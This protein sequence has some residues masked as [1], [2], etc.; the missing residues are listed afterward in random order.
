MYVVVSLCVFVLY[1][2]RLQLCLGDLFTVNFLWPW[3][4]VVYF[5]YTPCTCGSFNIIIL[6]HSGNTG[7]WA[8]ADYYCDNS[9]SSSSDVSTLL[10]YKVLQPQITRRHCNKFSV[11]PV[12]VT[13]QQYSRVAHRSL[14]SCRAATAPLSVSSSVGWIHLYYVSADS[15]TCLRQ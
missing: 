4:Q 14:A 7:R 8:W 11:M 2:P 3:Y 5:C 1:K 13:K 6:V 9:C 15:P 10:V 12:N